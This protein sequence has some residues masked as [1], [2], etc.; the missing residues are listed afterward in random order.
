[1]RLNKDKILWIGWQRDDDKN[2]DK[3]WGIITIRKSID[4]WKISAPGAYVVFWGR[5]GK[6]LRTKI[7]TDKYSWDMTELYHKKKIS[8]YIKVNYDQ[9]NSVY[10]EF[11]ED[12]DWTAVEAKL[13]V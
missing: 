3:V 6:T 8:G 5:R 9:L 4:D 12:L 13:S 7:H 11:E 2:V 1:M 10:P